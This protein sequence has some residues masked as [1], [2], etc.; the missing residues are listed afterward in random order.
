MLQTLHI[1]DLALIEHAEVPFAQ[2]LN[3]LSGA[4]GG[5][6]SLV[7]T[8]LKILRGEKVR[9][10]LVRHG[11]KELRVD[12]EFSIGDGERSAA[13]LGRVTEIVGE[14]FEEQSLLVT[15]IVDARGAESRPDRRTPRDVVRPAGDRSVVARDPRAGGL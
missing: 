3:V 4:T 8:A 5:G 12:G 9:G 14:P 15:R 11:Q 10:D 6:K 7:I 2:G 13:L 1:R